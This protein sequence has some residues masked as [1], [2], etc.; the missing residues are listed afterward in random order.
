MRVDIELKKQ[1]ETLKANNAEMKK[2]ISEN[3]N[4]NLTI[5]KTEVGVRDANVEIG[6]L[7]ESNNK[8]Y[9]E[10]L[11]ENSKKLAELDSKMKENTATMKRAQ[12]ELDGLKGGFSELTK[13]AEKDI[14]VR[15]KHN[16]Q[17]DKLIKNMREEMI[18]AE[19]DI[20]AAKAAA[21]N[22]RFALEKSI[23]GSMVTENEVTYARIKDYAKSAY[24]EM[25]S[26]FGNSVARVLVD[27]ESLKENMDKVF[28][29]IL[30]SFI[31]MIVEMQ[32]RSLA[33]RTLMGFGFG[34]P[35][36]A[37][38]TN[39][40]VDRP[41]LF[42]AGENGPERVKVSPMNTAHN[43]NR[44]TRNISVNVVNNISSGQA[45]NTRRLADQIGAQVISRIRGLGDMDFTRS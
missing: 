31:S 16:E 4:F 44:V 32:L 27:G 45:E 29:N 24:L 21:L 22:E 8:L 36:F 13:A 35:A 12:T 17:L 30:R 38:G 18:K 39:Q 10:G 41:T 3:E 23:M 15:K 19:K 43:D 37:T 7:N 20:T 26:G 25:A 5:N 1:I 9:K 28:K 42:M 14:E 34:V 2:A 6:K 33:I 40:M 11:S